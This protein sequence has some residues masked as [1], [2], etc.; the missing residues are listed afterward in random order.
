MPAMD[1]APKVEAHDRQ[2]WRDWLAANHATSR[3][4]WR[5]TWRRATGRATLDYEAAVEEALCFGWVDSQAGTIDAE[6]AK[7]YFAPRQARSGWARPNKDRVARLTAAGRM[8]P[9]GVAAVEAAKANGMWTVLDSVE[10]LEV[11][12]DLA[13]ALAARP[14]ARHHWDAFPRSVRRSILEW[15]A[16]A[17]RDD[18][19]RRRIEDAATMAHRNERAHQTASR[20]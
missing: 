11:P 7:Q 20:D 10:R 9:A 19:R 18:T 5:V 12:D 16:L 13:A 8:A 1:D 3:G 14:P 15:I 2:T 17:R 6:R 4:V